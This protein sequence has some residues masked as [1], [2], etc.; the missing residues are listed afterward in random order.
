MNLA[1][2]PLH[3]A[4]QDDRNPSRALGPLEAF[5]PLQWSAEDVLV[6]KISAHKAWFWVDGPARRSAARWVRNARTSS[7]PSRGDAGGH[8]RR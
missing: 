4:T 1:P 7:T 6:R 8:S 5:D 2:S 3:L